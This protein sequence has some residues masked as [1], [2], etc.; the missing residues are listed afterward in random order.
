MFAFSVNGKAVQT[1]KEQPLLFYLREELNLTSVKNGCAQGA[2][3]T[4]TILAD[5]KAARACTLT[6]K[7]A[8]GKNIVTCEGLSPRERD[9]YAYAFSRAGAV[10]CGFCTPGMVMASKGLLDVNPS[11]DR[12]A[13]KKAIRGNICRCTGYKKIVDA[14]LL[15]SEYL[16]EG[17]PLPEN[18][19]TGALGESMLRVDAPAKAAGT[20]EYAD[21]MRLPGM[22]Y[23]SAVRSEHPRA[24]VKSVDT[25]EA[26]KVPG[27]VAVLTAADVPAKRKIGHRTKDYDVMIP[28][29]EVT[30]F[31]GD[32]AR[33]GSRRDPRGAPRRQGKNPGEYEVLPAVL[34][35]KSAVEGRIVVHEEMGLSDNL[36]VEQTLIRGDAEAK[37]RSFE[38]CRH[39]ALQDPA[40][41]TCFSGT[42]DRRGPARRRRDSDSLRRPGDLPDPARVRRGAGPAGGKVRVVAKLVGGGFGGKEDMSVQH[43]AALLAYKPGGPSRSA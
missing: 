3:G 11:P 31:C 10:Q 41:G 4:C 25:S 8:V 29:G 43:H 22:L 33:P 21:D 27:V 26:K 19:D 34:D 32:A 16:R 20:A 5:G 30:H 37:N 18:A 1:E 13:I 35:L 7:G 38:I 36:Y 40:Y 2:C 24:L 6:T 42:G 39:P 9:V 12:N 28:V 14:V 17:K 23:G 15:A